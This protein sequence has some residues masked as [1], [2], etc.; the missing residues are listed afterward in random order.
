MLE[1]HDATGK[2]S[3]S[4]L[5]KAV[6]YWI[7]IKDVLKEY[8]KYVIVNIANEWM[9]S[10][11]GSS[12]AS[13]YKTAIKSLRNAG[14]DNMLVVDAPGWGQNG[15]NCVRYCQEVFN[16]DANKNTMFSIHM[17]ADA[18][19][20]AATVKSG[21]DAAYQMGICLCIGE[22]GCAHGTRDVDEYTIMSY[23]ESK[24]AGY[25]GWSW[26]GNNSDLYCCQHLQ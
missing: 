2:D 23:C 20:D 22:F 18:G 6:N 19:K 1:V 7:E 15:S 13:G 16:A 14:I 10:W 24:G 4:S 26:K 9:G 21:I 11:N 17:Y 5:T 12:W 8:E 3:T 25:L